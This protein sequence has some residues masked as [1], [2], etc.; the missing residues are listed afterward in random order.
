MMKRLFLAG[1]GSALAVLLL[2]VACT[3]SGGGKG[4][5]GGSGNGS[6]TPRDP[7]ALIDPRCVQARGPIEAL[8]R[9]EAMAAKLDPART[10][11]MVRDNTTMVMNECA[12][13]PQVGDCSVT[14]RS[15]QQLEADCLRPLDDEGTEG[16]T[17][18]R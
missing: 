10:E 4:S 6:A 3:C 13:R 1:R 5:G 15:A 16:S 9:A 8:Y 2:A 12:G 7:S 14:A 17:I 11:E 18:R